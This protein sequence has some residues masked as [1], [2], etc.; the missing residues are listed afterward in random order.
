[1]GLKRI[2]TQATQKSLV[3]KTHTLK[4]EQNKTRKHRHDTIM[5]LSCLTAQAT[6]KSLVQKTHTTKSGAK[7]N[8]KTPP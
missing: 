8:K 2:T 3:Q 4:A 7:Q 1:M 5:G 6:Q